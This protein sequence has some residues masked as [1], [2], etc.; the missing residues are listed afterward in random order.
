MSGRAKRTSKPSAAL[1]SYYSQIDGTPLIEAYETDDA[2][3]EV[4]EQ[5]R[6]N[7]KR[8]SHNDDESNDEDGGLPTVTSPQDA[9]PDASKKYNHLVKYR[10]LSQWWPALVINE[11]SKNLV[12]VE[13]F[14]GEQEYALT[15][16]SFRNR[17]PDKVISPHVEEDGVGNSSH[18][19]PPTST[20]PDNNDDDDNTNPSKTFLTLNWDE[21]DGASPLPVEGDIIKL[22]E[23]KNRA[24]PKRK[25]PSTSTTSRSLVN[26]KSKSVPATAA[27]KKTVS[28]KNKPIKKATAPTRK[29]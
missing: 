27:K 21:N 14:N 28:K 24:K 6:N 20:E 23:K 17:F 29:N 7:K 22:V 11:R 15:L 9:Y 26:R 1:L 12:D 5:R 4:Q 16:K 18:A 2:R 10:G 25:T 8:A 19:V 3:G 13:Y